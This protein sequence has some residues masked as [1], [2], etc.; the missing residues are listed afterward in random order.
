VPTA[1][2]FLKTRQL[3]DPT[4]RQRTLDQFS[5][6][7]IA[8]ERIVLG[9][10]ATRGELLAA[11]NEVDIALDPFPFGGGTTTAEALWMGVPVVSLR[12][13]RFVGRVGES[14]LSTIGLA[15]LVAGNADEYVATA[16][17]LAA[18]RPRLSALRAEL[19][20]RLLASPLCQPDRFTRALETAY[21]GMWRHWC[22][23]TESKP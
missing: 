12:G 23:S 18:D 11:Y 17:A 19:R 16:A 8:G 15:E 22:C 6:H 3:A 9:M 2:L 14:I 7:G 4:I 1:H 21:R 10:P 20:P 13:D 5:Q